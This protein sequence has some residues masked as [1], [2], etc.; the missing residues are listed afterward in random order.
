MK[1]VLI[2]LLAALGGLGVLGY[3][4]H[5]LIGGL[6][7]PATERLVIALACLVGAGVIGYMA[8]DVIKRR[9]NLR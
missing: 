4:V 6:V 7:D 1:E 5:M 8:W 9:R 2:Y 3:S